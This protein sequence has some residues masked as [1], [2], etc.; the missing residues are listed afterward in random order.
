MSKRASDEIER[1]QSPLSKMNYILIG[2]SIVMIIVGFILMS[3]SPNSVQEYNPDIFS[4]RRIV[5][6]PAI[7]FIGF[8]F[9]GGALM[10]K[11][12]K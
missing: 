6:G 5:V 2:V 7:A 12:R 1:S 8:V 10:Y 4:T 9:M 11:S 3:G